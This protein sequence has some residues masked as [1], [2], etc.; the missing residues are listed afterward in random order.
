MRQLQKLTRIVLTTSIVILSLSAAARAS[1]RTLET[2]FALSA[3]ARS[4][5]STSF[6]LLSAGR[7]VVEAD[8]NS[9][10]VS[11]TA[12]LLTLILIRPDGTTAASKSGASVLRL[13]HGA[14]DQDI[15][16]FAA[17]NESKWTVKI[18]NDAD[19]NRTEVSGTLRITIPAASR[20]LEDTQ[21]TLLG[22]GNA[23]E[24]PFKVPAPGKIQVGAGRSSEAVRSSCPGRQPDSSRRVKNLC[25][26]P[27]HKSDQG[28]AV[29]SRSTPS[30]SV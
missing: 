28:G 20:A 30:T 13:E 1:T 27:G 18:L 2:R 15:E 7:I 17:S 25:A 4:E 5:F 16:K 3:D 9:P 12:A 19:A 29:R 11:R 23:Q 8:W 22:S 21:F 24:I 26:S 10:A 6:P 14:S